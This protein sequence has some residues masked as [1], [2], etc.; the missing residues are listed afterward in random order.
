MMFQ[1]EPQQ[2]KDTIL[3]SYM[4]Q[5]TAEAALREWVFGQKNEYRQRSWKT[6]RS[7]WTQGE[8]RKQDWIISIAELEQALQQ[9]KHRSSGQD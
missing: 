4:N 5:Q 1:K 7:H 9:Y 2:N 3:I 6:Q 8:L